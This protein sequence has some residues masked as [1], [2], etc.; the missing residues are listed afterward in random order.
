MAVQGTTA[1]CLAA[2]MEDVNPKD[3]WANAYSTFVA[4][5]LDKFTALATALVPEAA[6]QAY[7]TL[8]LEAKTFLVVHGLC[9][10][11]SI[12]LSRSSNEGHLV[13]FEG[14]TL[15]DGKPPDLW[16]FKGDDDKLFELP[17]LA[18][19]VL[20]LIT[21]FYQIPGKNN[22]KWFDEAR[23]DEAGMWI[24]WLIP[25]PTGWAALLEDYPDL[26]TAFCHV[27]DLINSVAEEKVG[28]FKIL[29]WQMAYV[30]H[31]M[32]DLE[33]STSA[34]ALEWKRLPRS[35]HLLWWRSEAWHQ[36]DDGSGG[37]DLDKEGF[38][39]T[40][41]R[42][43]PP[44]DPPPPVNDFLS[45]LGGGGAP[46]CL[47]PN[48]PAPPT[49]SPHSNKHLGWQPVHQ[50]GATGTLGHPS[51]FHPTNHRSGGAADHHATSASRQSDGCHGS[52]QRQPHCLYYCY[53]P[54][55]GIQSWR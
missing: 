1:F 12:P 17:P 37:T 14:E 2:I 5:L 52:K 40:D 45:I 18:K 36:F 7:P 53:G 32:P 15:Q 55:P 43:M 11:V 38:A 23:P 24:S 29:A 31:L 25:I 35:K 50:S 28:N 8:D 48:T 6:A 49:S 27:T 42:K 20:S 4:T 51:T 41:N 46:S 9:R 34:L 22:D 30:S 33:E 47:V 19:T 13:A 3:N 10:W 39:T 44:E 26:G 16:Q 21:Q 54:S